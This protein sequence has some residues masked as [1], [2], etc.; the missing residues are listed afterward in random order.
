MQSNASCKL[1]AETYGR[2]G[3][4]FPEEIGEMGHFLK[5]QAPGYFGYAPIGLLQQY[6][7]LINHPVGNVVGGGFAGI[8]LQYFV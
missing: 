7:R 6:F 3:G 2:I 8:F 4:S 5:T 1:A